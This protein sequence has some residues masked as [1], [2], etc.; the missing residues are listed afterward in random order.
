MA[1]TRKATK[2]EKV[3]NASPKRPNFTATKTSIAK[4]DG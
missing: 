4:D 3:K 2:M 1:R